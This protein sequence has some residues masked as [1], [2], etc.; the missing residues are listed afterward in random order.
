MAEVNMKLT[1]LVDEVV[2]GVVEDEGMHVTVAV[3][4]VVAAVATEL[5]ATGVLPTGVVVALEAVGLVGV[6]VVEEGLA[7]ARTEKM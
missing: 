5:T 3:V 2:D 7:D 6:V 4:V 1:N